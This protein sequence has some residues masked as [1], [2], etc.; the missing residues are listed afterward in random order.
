[1]IASFHIADLRPRG[2]PF[3]GPGAAPVLRFAA[4]MMKASLR[5]GRPHIG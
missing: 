2:A 4:T 3:A 5:G 1:M